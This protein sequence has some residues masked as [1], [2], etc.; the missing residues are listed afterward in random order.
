MMI[1]IG[2]YHSVV[3]SSSPGVKCRIG[4]HETLA[5]LE[6]NG[7][8]YAADPSVITAVRGFLHGVFFGHS[9]HKKTSNLLGINLLGIN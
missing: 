1:P 8:H 7:D 9:T 6:R 4:T 2:I 5:D 3:N